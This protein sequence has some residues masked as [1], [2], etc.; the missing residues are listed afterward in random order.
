MQWTAPCE[1]AE[2]ESKKGSVKLD[3]FRCGVIV[4]IKRVCTVMGNI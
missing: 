4:N 1:E 3:K 2:S